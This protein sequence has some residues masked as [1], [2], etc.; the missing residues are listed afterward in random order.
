MSEPTRVFGWFA[1][2]LS[3]VYKFPQIYKLQKTKDTRGISVFSQCVQASAYGF[4]IAHGLI[5]SDPPVWF[6]GI[7]SLCQSMVLIFQYFAFRGMAS[8]R[9]SGKS[10]HPYDDTEDKADVLD[11]ERLDPD[12]KL[13][14]GVDATAPAS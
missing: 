11:S 8:V 13:K 14:G 10:V 12:L 7:A 9:E 4:Y 1:V 5:I 3:L 6:L 2:A